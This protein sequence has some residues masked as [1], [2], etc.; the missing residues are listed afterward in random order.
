MALDD[1]SG[2][3]AATTLDDIGVQRSLH[4]EQRV[5]EA[6]SVLFEDAHEQFANGLALQLWIGD[7][8]KALEEALPGIDMNEF[9]AHVASKR[10]DDLI[11]FALT[12]QAGVYVHAGEL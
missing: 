12:H 2:A 10:F 3:V 7:S 8:C 1:R 5:G 11:A 6:A 9:D 4:Q